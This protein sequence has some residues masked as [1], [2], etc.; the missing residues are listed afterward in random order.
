ME[1]ALRAADG[2]DEACVVPVGDGA[3]KRLIGFL[4]CEH[5]ADAAA[6]AAGALA[7]CKSRLPAYS[8]PSRLHLLAPQLPDVATAAAGGGPQGLSPEAAEA[9]LLESGREGWWP[10]SANGKVDRKELK[11]FHA[12]HADGGADGAGLGG[13]GDTGGGEGEAQTP[14][15]DTETGICAIWASVLSRD[16]TNVHANWFDLG[17]D[18]IKMIGAMSHLNAKFSSKLNG[19]IQSATLM[20]HQ[21]VSSLAAHIDGVDPSAPQG[22]ADGSTRLIVGMQKKGSLPPLF[23]IAP[24]SGTISCY[25][26]LSK[27]LGPDQ[28]FYALQHPGLEEG[29]DVFQTVEEMAASFV[30]DL[31]GLLATLPGGIEH[32]SFSLG[33][34]SMGGVIACEVALQLLEQGVTVRSVV[35]IDSPAPSGTINMDNLSTTAELALSYANDITAYRMEQRL[36]A[37]SELAGLSDEEVKVAVLEALRQQEPALATMSPERFARHLA[38]YSSNTRALAAYKPAATSALFKSNVTNHPHLTLYLLRAEATNAHLSR[39]PAAGSHDFGWSNLGI[40]KSRLRVYA[41]CGDHYGLLPAP[42]ATSDG[43]GGGLGANDA[44]TSVQIARTLER[45]LPVAARRKQPR[46][47]TTSVQTLRHSMNTVERASVSGR[48]VSSSRSAAEP[49]ESLHK[50][51]VSG[52]K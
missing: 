2:V 52:R 31:K 28:P 3:K 4:K 36:P 27:L 50:D 10:L 48:R 18:S 25:N 41:I 9:A 42:A 13:A 16:V 30:S 46:F 49:T 37:V 33:G 23:F 8:Q 24:V 19:V 32:G 51:K 39:Y 1:A 20:E 26:H 17:G 38:V 6:I 5:T 21:T 14:R 45:I 29:E 7:S 22:P 40:P 11:R 47:K 12:S 35:L 15:T 34:W 44:A 43:A